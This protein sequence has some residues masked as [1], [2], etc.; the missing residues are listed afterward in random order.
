MTNELARLKSIID[1]IQEEVDNTLAFIADDL[2][3]L[4]HENPSSFKCGYNTGLKAG[5]LAVDR[6]LQGLKENEI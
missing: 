5:M 2:P 1:F 6:I 4:V 3:I